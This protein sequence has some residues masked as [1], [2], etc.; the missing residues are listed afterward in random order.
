ML[1]EIRNTLGQ[2][3]GRT[4]KF[5]NTTELYDNFG[6]KLGS[7]NEMTNQVVDNLG[8]VVGYG[9]DLLGILLHK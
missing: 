9:K 4:Q 5:G 3:V 2:V 8:R 1:N 7:H 6:K